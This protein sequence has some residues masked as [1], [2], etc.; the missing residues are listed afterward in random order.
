MTK[1]V[2]DIHPLRPPGL[3]RDANA[4]TGTYSPSGVYGDATLATQAKGERLVEAL[5]AAIRS[6]VSALRR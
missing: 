2:R 5:L 6:D 4:A 1:A 3:T